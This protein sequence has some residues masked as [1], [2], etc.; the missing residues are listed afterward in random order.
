MRFHAPY[1][2]WAKTRPSPRFDLAGSNVL[3]VRAT[4]AAGDR[5]PD[6]PVWNEGGYGNNVV[7]RIGVKVV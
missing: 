1:M 5:Q 6:S 7:H 2:E 3:A 4:D